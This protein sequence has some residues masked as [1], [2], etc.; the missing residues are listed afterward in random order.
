MP[1]DSISNLPDNVRG[2]LPKHAQEIYQSAFNN[3][4]EHYKDPEERRGSASREETAHRVAWSAVKEKYE[5]KGD[6]WRPINQ[7]NK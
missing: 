6:E 5:K 7:T 2:V 4:W 3:A 1:Y